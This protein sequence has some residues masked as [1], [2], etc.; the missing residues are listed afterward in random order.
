MKTECTTKRDMATACIVENKNA[1]SQISDTPPMQAS[2]I[3]A[4]GFDVKQ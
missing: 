4:R 2:H 1:F 3:N